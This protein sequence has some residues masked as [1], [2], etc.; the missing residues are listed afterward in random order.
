MRQFG[1]RLADQR[2]IALIMQPLRKVGK[3]LQP[4]RLPTGV[5]GGGQIVAEG[6]VIG[7]RGLLQLARQLGV[8]TGHFCLRRAE[9][10]G[11][12]GQALGLLF[13]QIAGELVAQGLHHLIHEQLGA[14]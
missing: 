6:I 5:V 12:V 2:Q 8:Q 4:Q 3:A 13:I 7:R 11:I 10:V 9:G 1:Q 14:I